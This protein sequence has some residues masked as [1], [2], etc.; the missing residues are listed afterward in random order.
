MDLFGALHELSQESE[1]P[2]KQV[3]I[4][5]MKKIVKKAGKN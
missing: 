3:K 1:L 2:N 4:F 5:S